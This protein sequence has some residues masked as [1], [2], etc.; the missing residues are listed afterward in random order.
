VNL[1]ATSPEGECCAWLSTRSYILFVTITDGEL[2][3]GGGCRRPALGATA[4]T[5]LPSF[6]FFGHTGAQN[7]RP[8]ALQLTNGWRCMRCGSTYRVEVDHIIGRARSKFGRAHQWMPRNLQILCHEHNQEKMTRCKCQTKKQRPRENI[9]AYCTRLQIDP[10]T[11]G[12]GAA[13]AWQDG[14]NIAQSTDR[15]AI[16]VARR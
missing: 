2:M 11:I 4:P 12:Y 15:S 10:R 13:E 8:R 6:G 16:G 7:G 9:S 5:V 3:S 1:H 14:P